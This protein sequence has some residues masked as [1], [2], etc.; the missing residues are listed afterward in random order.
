MSRILFINLIGGRKFVKRSA[1]IIVGA[2]L[3]LSLALH[4]MV[5][6]KRGDV[7]SI[8]DKVVYV[9]GKKLAEPTIIPLRDHN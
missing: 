9:N 8:R 6:S 4:F 3:L 7:V 2:C 1:F 5:G